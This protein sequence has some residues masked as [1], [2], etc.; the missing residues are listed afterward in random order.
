M[1][2]SVPHNWQ[3]DLLPGLRK[4]KIEELYAKLAKDFVGGG[5]A[6]CVLPHV[7]KK[8]VAMF[9]SEAHKNGIQFNY[10]LNAT[11]LGNQ[12]WSIKGQR[13]LTKLLDW[14]TD[15]GV[16][17]VTIS[18]PYLLELIKKRYPK[19]KVCV[20]TQAGV[21]SIKRA[22]HW[23]EL[24]AERITLA[25]TSVN[26]NFP[27]LRQIR[28][29][30]KCELQL[31]ANLECLY[32]CPF[33]IYHSVLNSH[34]SQDNNAFLID[35]CYLSCNYIRLK[36]PVEFIKAGWIR[37][38]D[39]RHYEAIGIDSLKLVNRGMTTEEI[40]SVVDAYT[41]GHYDGNLLD[42]FSH[43]SKNI[44]LQ[45]P[46][47]LHKLRYFFRPFHVNLFTLLKARKLLGGTKVYIDNR[48]L[49][50]FIEYFLNENCSLKSCEDCGY[51]NRVA[52]KTVKISPD[53]RS[54]SVCGYRKYLDSLLSG[55]MFDYRKLF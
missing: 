8:K 20:S 22:R 26:R 32:Q 9:V 52:E 48:S 15:I 38:E 45:R 13:S 41:K 25:E 37:P 27:L 34:G 24:G 49:D 7:S 40:I 33:W 55:E 21:D 18:M 31:I 6:S 29:A 3:K 1:K 44:I 54:E 23:E 2:F 53:W 36:N 46:N 12:E 43:P 28:R 10:L 30:V 51:C 35:Y 17:K 16:D 50:G 4:F 14:L 47:I 42:L 39:I 19:L 11:C 5:R